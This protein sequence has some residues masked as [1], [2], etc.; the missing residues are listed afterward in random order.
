MELFHLDTLYDENINY[1][2]NCD[3]KFN[4][5]GNLET[6]LSSISK[7]VIGIILNKDNIGNEV[8]IDTFFPY[9]SLLFKGRKE[10]HAYNTKIMLNENVFFLVNQNVHY[11]YQITTP[12]S[13]LM[14]F[15]SEDF[16]NSI[17]EKIKDTN[18]CEIFPKKYLNMNKKDYYY[19]QLDR[20]VR[21]TAVELI[22]LYQAEDKTNDFLIRITQEKLFFYLYKK[23]ILNQ[24]LDLSD[25][26][27]NDILQ[28]GI[29]YLNQ[30]FQEDISIEK[31][32]SEIGISFNKF[33]EL[34]KENMKIKPGHYLIELRMNQARKLLSKSDISVSEVAY[35][36]GYNS[37]S[38][39]IKRFKAYFKI[40]P[41]QFQLKN[42]K[43]LEQ[44]C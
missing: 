39:F 16:I 43:Q 14:L 34:F 24:V 40:T 9:F 12:F 19:A 2:S 29:K 22:D 17:L 37:L 36:V 38:S 20:E 13:E 35:Q 11:K 7:G 4:Q 30:H 10:I 44:Y 26:L 6:D 42:R 25:F 33:N 27:D 3:L 31:M 15:F 32:C 5:S 21:E 8:D 41:K 23:G 18:P 28:Q 1:Q